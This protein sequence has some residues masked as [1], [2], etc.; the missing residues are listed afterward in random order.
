MYY[1]FHDTLE[2]MGH[3]VECIDTHKHTQEE[4]GRVEFNESVLDLIKSR[5]YDAMIVATFGDAVSYTHLTLPTILL[6]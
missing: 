2:E 1:Y 3:E 5:K 4:R 6:V